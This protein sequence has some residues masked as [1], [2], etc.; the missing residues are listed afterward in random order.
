MT[1]NELSKI[2]IGCAI[3]VHKILGPGLLE[4][5][6]EKALVFELYLKGLSVLTQV[7]IPVI[8]KEKKLDI[9]YRV[10][11]LVENKVI[12]EIKSVENLAPIHFAQTLT[13]IKLS[14]I[15]LGLLINFNTIILKEGIQRI[16]NSL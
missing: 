5:V 12:V 4:S 11:V 14:N 16:V 13:Y 10:D 7:P 1:E 9:G 3:D 2:I 15:K 8:Y 6:Y